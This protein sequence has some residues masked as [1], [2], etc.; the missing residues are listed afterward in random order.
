MSEQF[1]ISQTFSYYV[2][3]ILLDRDTNFGSTMLPRE[4]KGK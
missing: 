1:R 3:S 4:G 2:F